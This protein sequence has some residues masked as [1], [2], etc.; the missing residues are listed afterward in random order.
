MVVNA[1]ST[2]LEVEIRRDAKQY[3]ISFE[4]GKRKTKLKQTGTVGQ[5]NTGT[6]LRFWP[7]A[8]YFDSAKFSARRLAHVLRAKAVLCPGLRITFKDEIA[9]DQDE[10]FYEDGLKNYVLSAT[11]G[12]EV[13]PKEPFIG[14]F[15]G[16][17]EAV[18]WAV[19]WMPE[20][21]DVLAESFVNLIPT[22]Q[23]GTH[24][25]GLRT[26]MLD[27]IREYCE[28]RALLPKGLKLTADDIWERCS[29]V[30]SAKLAD[31]Q[32][33]GQTKERLS[34]QDCAQYVAGKS[35]LL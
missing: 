5:R 6:T 2:R 25:N 3:A 30:L 32:F 19:Q 13:V 29:Y 35:R 1:L 27:A 7:D 23:G 11:R 15:A 21:G 33:S 18:D 20:G 16:D 12:W 10:W 4:N 22:A 28:F 14:S 31:P 24:V 8:G 26:G 9:K 17:T 34:S